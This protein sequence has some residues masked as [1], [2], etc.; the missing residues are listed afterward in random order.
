MDQEF[1]RPLIG[2]ILVKKGIISRDQLNIALEEQKRTGKKLASILMKLGFVG[3]EDIGIALSEQIGYPYIDLSSYE[4]DKDCLSKIPFELVSKHSIMPV[5]IIGDALTVAM[6]N[7]LDVDAID[8]VRRA[9]GMTIRPIF[10]TPTSIKNSIEKYYKAKVSTDSKRDFMG[11]ERGVGGGAAMPEEKVSLEKHFVQG[12][13]DRKKAAPPSP[14]DEEAIKEAIQPSIINTVNKLINDAVES[15]AS[16]IHLEPD[17]HNFYIRYRVDGVLYDSVFEPVPKKLEAAIISRIKIMAEMDI[18][19]RRLPQDGRINMV[20]GDKK[21]DLR[22]S[23]FPTIYGENISIRILDKTSGFYR[24]E[25]LGFSQAALKKLKEMIRKPFGIMLVTGPTGSGKTTTLYGVLNDINEVNKNIITLEDP[26]EYVISRIRQSQINPKAGLT[27]ANGLRSI[28]RQD[29]DII[30][31]GEIRDVET[32]EISIHAALTGHLVFSTLHTNNASSAVTRLLNMGIEPFLI[33]SSLTGVVAQ[34]LIRKLCFKCRKEYKPKDE[35]IEFLEKNL[36][37]K[38]NKNTMLYKE[39]GCP[40]CKNKGYKGRIGIYEL[41]T[42]DEDIKELVL[43]QAAAYQ[44]EEVAKKNGMRTLKEDG[45]E[46][47][48]EGI[49]TISEIMRVAESI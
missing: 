3:E 26:V 5:Y 30:M 21:I 36:G 24:L 13:A 45:Y 20:V 19:E 8:E 16:D 2:E 23:S 42:V 43:K 11:L 4:I 48:L 47:V 9:T 40:E 25:D 14:R 22:I 33:S 27:F 32:A 46:K 18:T 41:L 34:R 1:G 15:K 6:V 28:L 39:T 44:I 37:R 38:L 49:T 10:A 7:P 17:E 12:Q 31:I 29:P 35:E